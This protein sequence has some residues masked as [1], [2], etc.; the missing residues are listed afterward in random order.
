M[1][2]SWEQLLLEVD[3]LSLAYKPSVCA[4]EIHCCWIQTWF[5]QSI[6]II[7]SITLAHM[8]ISESFVFCKTSGMKAKVPLLPWKSADIPPSIELHLIVFPRYCIFFFFFF[9]NWAFVWNLHCWMM[10]SIF[11]QYFCLVK[12][13]ASCF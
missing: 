3:P 9:K 4:Q 13:C 5:S 7:R 10:V 6:F 11:Q 8:Y 2:N 12:S 1:H